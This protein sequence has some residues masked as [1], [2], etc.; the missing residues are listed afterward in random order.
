MSDTNNGTTY[1]NRNVCRSFTVGLTTG[2]LALANQICS[3]VVVLN[4][5][6]Q[7]VL[8]YDGGFSAAGNGFLVEDAQ[9]FTFR[10]LT[11]AMQL[12][13]ATVAGTGNLSYRTQYYS[14][15][16]Q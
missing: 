7:S 12:S 3:E 13:A 1:I 10:G 8:F 16:Q 6:G 11:N 9:T 14:Y 5:T 4:N 2:L 15:S